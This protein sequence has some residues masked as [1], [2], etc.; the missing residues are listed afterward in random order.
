MGGNPPPAMPP[1]GPPIPPQIPPRALFDEALALLREDKLRSFR[2]VVE[3]N[4]TIEPDATQEKQARVEF[5][6]AVTQFL[7]QAQEMAAAYPTV[8]PVLGK[9]LLFGARGFQ[10]GRELESALEGLISDLERMAKTPAPKPP[11]PEE[12]K[13]QTEQMKAQADIQK[14][15]M[16]LQAKQQDF[17]MEQQRFS[18]E[19]EKMKMDLQFEREKLEL[20]RQKLMMEM[21]AKREDRAMDMQAKQEDRA[22]EVTAKQQDLAIQA[23]QNEQQ[24]AHD[25][26]MRDRKEA[27]EHTKMDL[28]EESIL[29]E[30]AA[31]RKAN[32][33]AG[34]GKRRADA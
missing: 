3:T 16:D 2:I 32:A 7:A 14:A 28:A 22:L 10:V 25:D 4:S 20:E 5:L 9:M 30:A 11:S 33:A 24:A 26:R 15:G 27:H 21:Q 19:I 13:A 18:M 6:G 23:D 12:I 8:M 31:T 17:Q 34:N 29:R 1:A